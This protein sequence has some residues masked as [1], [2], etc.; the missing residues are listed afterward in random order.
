M[1]GGRS[2]GCRWS[3]WRSAGSC[4]GR[5]RRWRCAG[6]AVT[7]VGGSIGSDAARVCKSGRPPASASA[8][9]KCRAKTKPYRSSAPLYGERRLPCL[10]ANCL[11]H[12]LRLAALA[13]VATAG[14]RSAGHRATGA[15]R[16]HAPDQR[17]DVPHQRADGRAGDSPAGAVQP[18]PLLRSLRRADQSTA[19]LPGALR[20]RERPTT[21]RQRQLQRLEDRKRLSTSEGRSARGPA[22]SFRPSSRANAWRQGGPDPTARPDRRRTAAR[23]SSAAR[24]RLRSTRTRRGSTP[25][26]PSMTLVFSSSTM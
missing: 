14:I 21:A 6:L 18:G 19:A 3:A 9:R 7:R 11:A 16:H 25:S 24:L 26:E 20:H 5:L 12:H 22:G 4:G 15:H 1:C 17:A 23:M 10:F 13:L 2:M 8:V